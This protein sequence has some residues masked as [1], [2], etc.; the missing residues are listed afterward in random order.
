MVNRINHTF[1]IQTYH[2]KLTTHSVD[3]NWHNERKC[4]TQF[5]Y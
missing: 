5:E 3:H 1:V 4:D 2:L